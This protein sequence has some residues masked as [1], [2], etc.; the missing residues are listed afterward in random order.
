M[1]R[2]TRHDMD[3][4]YYVD[5]DLA[6]GDGRSNIDGSY[7]KQGDAITRLAE[8]EDTELTPEEIEDLKE[9]DFN[10]EQCTIAQHNEIHDLRDEINRVTDERDAAVADFKEYVNRNVSGTH[11]VYACDFCKHRDGDRDCKKSPCD[12]LQKWQWRG[13]DREVR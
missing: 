4:G 10:K 12:G 1:G 13:A 3:I 8:Y 5:A 7:I 6:D 2:L 11:G 9:S